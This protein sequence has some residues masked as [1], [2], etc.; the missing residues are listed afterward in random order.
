MEWSF[1]IEAILALVANR[2]WRVRHIDVITAFLNKQITKDIFV[3]V[4]EGF[5]V[6]EDPN[7]V[8]RLNWTRHSMALNMHPRYEN[9]IFGW[10]TKPNPKQIQSTHVLLHQWHRT[11]YHHTSLHGWLANYMT[12][13]STSTK[14]QTYLA[15]D[16][17]LG[18]R[19]PLP[20][21]EL[22]LHK[23]CIWEHQSAYIKRLLDKFG[24]IHCNESDFPM[25]LW[26]KLT[27]ETGISTSPQFCRWEPHLC[28]EHSIE[29]LVY[30]EQHK[31]FYGC[32]QRPHL[33]APKQVLQYLKQTINYNL[34]FSSK[35]QDILHS[36]GDP[37]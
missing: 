20:W 8:V 11:I 1:A 37:D 24:M 27:K 7:I 13:N 10:E 31:S 25:D 29:H 3:E 26:C 32:T 33:Q 22:E 23:I 30:N 2:K 34:H 35:I 6:H 17:R 36:F 9:L 4:L 21:L 28:F 19:H 15:R 5:E 14:I 12:L 18:S 16:D